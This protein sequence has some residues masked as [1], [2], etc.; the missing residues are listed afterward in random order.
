MYVEMVDETGQV[1]PEMMKQ[2]QYLLDFATEK[3][4]KEKK[5]WL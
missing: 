5:K 3:L 1:S 2:T 4:G